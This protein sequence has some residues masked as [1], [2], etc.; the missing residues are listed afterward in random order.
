MGFY[1]IRFR[2]TC[3]IVLFST[4]I[5]YN[6]FRGRLLCLLGWG[7]LLATI[8]YVRYRWG[9]LEP[10]YDLINVGNPFMSTYVLRLSDGYLIID[11]NFSFGWSQLVSGLRAEN[12]S[13]S[14][15]KYIFV[16]HTHPDHVGCLAK[17]VAATSARIIGIPET[18]AILKTGA[19]PAAPGMLPIGLLAKLMASHFPM[20]FD[21]VDVPDRSLIFDGSENF[22]RD[23]GIPGRVLLLPGHSA[24]S[25]GLL[26]DDGRLFC[27]DAAGN[28]LPG[29]ERHAIVADNLPEYLKS[30]DTMIASSPKVVYPAHGLKFNPRDLIRYRHSLDGQ[31][32][33][34]SSPA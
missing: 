7:L 2:L 13:L 17:L 33:P 4:L 9:V 14:E 8:A 15:I 28:G 18:F 20:R 27:G 24:D 22:L 19:A 1:E 30:W 23:L 34:G 21:P 6:L 31:Q 32:L 25:I 10:G 26:L 3:L 29:I 16:T 12:I 11:S 5:L